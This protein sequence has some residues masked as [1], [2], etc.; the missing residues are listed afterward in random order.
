M[1][2][3]ERKKWEIKNISR[4]INLKTLFLLFYFHP[5]PYG[6]YYGLLCIFDFA[7]KFSTISTNVACAWIILGL[8]ASFSLLLVRSHQVCLKIRKKIPSYALHKH[9]LLLLMQHSS[10]QRTENISFL[11]SFTTSYSHPLTQVL[12]DY[13]HKKR[14]Y[15]D[16]GLLDIRERRLFL[17]STTLHWGWNSN[18]EKIHK[19][20]GI[21]T[22]Q[23]EWSSRRLWSSREDKGNIS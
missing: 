5:T 21:E 19:E 8:L 10:L 23:T 1:T 11:I 18:N 13:K 17:R 7:T 14:N 15:N 16:A 6:T 9:L 12:C 22:G 2:E 4:V 3:L 20:R